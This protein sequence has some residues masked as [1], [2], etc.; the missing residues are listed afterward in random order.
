MY[1]CMLMMKLA[2]CVLMFADESKC[3]FLYSGTCKP[4]LVLQPLQEGHLNFVQADCAYSP[5]CI[6][7]SGVNV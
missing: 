6:H 1:A 3:T 7:C 2:V 5:T 4:Y